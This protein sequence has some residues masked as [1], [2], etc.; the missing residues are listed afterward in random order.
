MSSPTRL[1]AL[2]AAALGLFAQLGNARS[3]GMYPPIEHRKPHP[4]PRHHPHT[5]TKHSAPHPD[6]AYT[7]KKNKT[8]KLGK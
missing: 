6:L 3:P 4:A 7:P 2:T 5:V 1:V 8:L